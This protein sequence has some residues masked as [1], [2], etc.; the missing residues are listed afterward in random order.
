MKIMLQNI[1]EIPVLEE[2]QNT[3]IN[4]F[5]L[6]V[7]LHSREIQTNQKSFDERRKKDGKMLTEDDATVDT[8][9]RSAYRNID[10][11]SVAVT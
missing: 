7:K 9:K 2:L 5:N 6:Q 10:S 11:T 1:L 8:F 4:E 3:F